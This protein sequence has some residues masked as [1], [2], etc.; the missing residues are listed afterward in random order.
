MDK[1]IEVVQERVVS[2]ALSVQRLWLYVALT[3]SV[4]SLFGNSAFQLIVFQFFVGLYRY[5]TNAIYNA[6]GWPEAHHWPNP[7]LVRDLTTLA[8]VCFAMATLKFNH[9]LKAYRA[10][11]VALVE[12]EKATLAALAQP[13]DDDTDMG[14]AIA[15]GTLFGLILGGPIGAIIGAAAGGLLGLAASQDKEAPTTTPEDVRATVQSELAKG[16]R[17]VF[18]NTVNRVVFAAFVGLLV[19]GLDWQSK[20]LIDVLSRWDDRVVYVA[21]TVVEDLNSGHPTFP[22]PT[23]VTAPPESEVAPATPA[24]VPVKPSSAPA[25]K[26][27]VSATRRLPS[28][29]TGTAP[30]RAQ[31][32][33]AKAAPTQTVPPAP[34][35]VTVRYIKNPVWIRRPNATLV[36]AKYPTKALRR[37]IDGRVV[38]D[39]SVADDGSLSDCT[40]ASESPS[41]EGFA[42]ATLMLASR[43]RLSPIDGDGQRISGA[44]IRVPI[45]WQTEDK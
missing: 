20:P 9:E 1:P 3:A 28:A 19:I 33:P 21:Q 24:T 45:V 31:A 13:V 16:R 38:I 26:P 12:N 15:S 35:A 11:K 42:E 32:P 39:C 2:T 40:I 23:T 30:R 36:R 5:P 6:L 4:V 44:R 29:A 41:G 25:P 34:V 17:A 27:G 8:I 7:G 18:I 10:T 22:K 14:G 43:F 37:G